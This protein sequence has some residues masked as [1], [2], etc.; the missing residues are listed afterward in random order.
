MNP[1]SDES[2]HKEGKDSDFK[3]WI[4]IIMKE[5]S[6]ICLGEAKAQWR[7]RSMKAETV[8]TLLAGFEYGRSG[9]NVVV[10]EEAP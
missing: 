1:E 10:S 5:V 3:V 6:Y 4:K 8:R 2:C 9:P 7:V